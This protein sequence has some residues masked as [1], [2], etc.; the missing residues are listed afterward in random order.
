MNVV[1]VICS[2]DFIFHNY[3]MVAS[4]MRNYKMVSKFCVVRVE[5]LG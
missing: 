2:S 1:I 3:I 4:S 5:A